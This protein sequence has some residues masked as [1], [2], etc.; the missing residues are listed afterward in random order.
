[1]TIRLP[2]LEWVSLHEVMPLL[3]ERMAVNDGGVFILDDWRCKYIDARIDMRTGHV[4]LRPGNP[5]L[6]NERPID[7]PDSTNDAKGKQ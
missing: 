6:R 3:R 7:R 5:Q 1:M 2:M 4:Y